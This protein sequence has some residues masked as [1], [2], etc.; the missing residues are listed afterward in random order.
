[1]QLDE[2]LVELRVGDALFRGLLVVPAGDERSRPCVLVAHTIRGRSD[3][4]RD[5]A[6]ELARLGYAGL[7][8]DVFG[9]EAE[10]AP[11]AR[12]RSL[13]QALCEDRRTLRERL[14]AWL[15]LARR[16]QGV[17][18]GRIAA[19]GFCFG[20]LCALDLARS[21]AHLAGVVSFH[22]LLD[23]APAGSVRPIRAKVLVLHGWEDPLATP[24]QAVALAGELTAAGADW[25][26]HAYGNTLHAFTNPAA[27]DRD[28]GLMYNA[29][30][31]RRSW[32]ALRSFLEELFDGS[33]T[34]V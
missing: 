3:F 30:A 34:A 20:G 18:A 28:A 32:A 25:Q 11:A 24:E 22:G 9:K 17:D 29:D 31:D 8:I 10:G 15:D 19:I 6:R 13:M 16:Q 5:K 12:L 1:M 26:I 23:A 14:T 2:R 4:E 21:G 27:A 33:A 7:A